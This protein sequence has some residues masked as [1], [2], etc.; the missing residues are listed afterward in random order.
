MAST[1][2]YTTAANI[3]TLIP[4]INDSV[5]FDTDAEIE[6][7]INRQE[8]VVNSKLAIKYTVP[9]S[10]ANGYAT[11]PTIITHYTEQL[12]I[13][14]ILITEYTEDSVNQNEWVEKYCDIIEEI[15][16]I[17]EG[18]EIIVDD[19]GDELTER[20]DVILTE[21]GDRFPVFDM[22]GDLNQRVDPD[23]IDDIT[24]DRS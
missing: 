1:H 14:K 21:R 3:V 10:V 23:L 13:C 2:G 15:E 8:A 4:N 24:N 20:G 11:V 17:V 18:E 22:D 12:T 19:D 16:K 9:F 6:F 7:Y 5:N